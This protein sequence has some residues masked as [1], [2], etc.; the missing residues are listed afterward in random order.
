M[1]YSEFHYIEKQTEPQIEKV[2]SPMLHCPKEQT[3]VL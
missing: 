3:K 1:Y 2:T